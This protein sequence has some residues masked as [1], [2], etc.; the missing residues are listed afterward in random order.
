MAK[1]EI[2]FLGQAEE[3]GQMVLVDRCTIEARTTKEAAEKYAAL[4]TDGA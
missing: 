2:T 3:N 1:F 4:F